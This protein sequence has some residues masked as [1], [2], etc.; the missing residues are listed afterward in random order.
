[1]GGLALNGTAET[2]VILFEDHNPVLQNASGLARLDGDLLD[3][4]GSGA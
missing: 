3:W 4:Q 2:T 1:M